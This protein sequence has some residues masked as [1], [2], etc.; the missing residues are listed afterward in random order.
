[1][2]NEHDVRLVALRRLRLG[3]RMFTPGQV[4]HVSGTGRVRAAWG[5]VNTQQAK[6]ADDA[7]RLDIELYGLLRRV[8]EREA[9]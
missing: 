1:M 8:G 7:S 9:A 2:T 5:L 4:I 6:P 3:G